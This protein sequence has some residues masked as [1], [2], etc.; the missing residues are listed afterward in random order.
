MSDLLGLPVCTMPVILPSGSQK[1]HKHSFAGF[2]NG[3]PIVQ[4]GSIGQC[5]SEV[6]QVVRIESMWQPLNRLNILPACQIKAAEPWQSNALWAL[7]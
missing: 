7:C 5:R 3:A 4:A 6:L 2:S 1:L